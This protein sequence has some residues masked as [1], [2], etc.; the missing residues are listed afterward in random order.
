VVAGC[1]YHYESKNVIVDRDHDE[2]A[3]EDMN[4]IDNDQLRADKEVENETSNASVRN[5]VECYDFLAKTMMLDLY[6]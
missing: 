3:I 1:Q 5:C 6:Y 2:E 4:E